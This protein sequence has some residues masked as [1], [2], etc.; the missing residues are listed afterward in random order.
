MNLHEVKKLHV[1]E[2]RDMEFMEFLS[3]PPLII[4]RHLSPCKGN[5]IL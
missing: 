5:A 4:Q 1:R 2:V 3:A